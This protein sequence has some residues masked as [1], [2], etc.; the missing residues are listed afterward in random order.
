MAPHEPYFISAL[1]TRDPALWM[2][3][4]W[5]AVYIAILCTG[6]TINLYRGT[7]RCVPESSCMGVTVIVGRR[8]H[9][10]YVYLSLIFPC[11]Y[12][13]EVTNCLL[14]SRFLEVSENTVLEIPC[15][16]VL[17]LQLARKRVT[18]SIGWTYEGYP[19]KKR[20][21]TLPQTGIP[22][23]IYDHP[24]FISERQTE[25]TV[26]RSGLFHFHKSTIKLG[27][28]STD[29]S[30]LFV[31]YVNQSPSGKKVVMFLEILVFPRL[32]FAENWKVSL[33]WN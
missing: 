33:E 28:Q 27:L 18:Y 24:N 20:S 25:V 1:L 8:I 9:S 21:N 2:T 14:N 29:C 12:R 19:G 11:C 7:M 4:Q 22:G 31:E 17:L 23:C 32:F 3:Y 5:L 13:K 26:L 6:Q 15:Q 10:A 16:L 30:S